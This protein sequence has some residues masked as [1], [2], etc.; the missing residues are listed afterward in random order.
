MPRRPPKLNQ[1]EKIGR[2]GTA[3]D[4]WRQH[5]TPFKAIELSG[6]DAND[7]SEAEDGGEHHGNDEGRARY[8]HVS[9]VA[10]GFV[11]EEAC[12][13]NLSY[14]YSVSV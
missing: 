6:G 4:R 13:F 10:D 12:R 11:C 5:K 2:N 14:K 1:E 9:S 3:A 8:A 7:A